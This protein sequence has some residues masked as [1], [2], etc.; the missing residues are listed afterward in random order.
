MV[1][2]RERALARA[3]VCNALLAPSA[4]K[5]GALLQESERV[6]LERAVDRL[7]LSARA[8]QRI[9]RVART[10]ADLGGH[11]QIAGEHL[12]EAIGYRRLDRQLAVAAA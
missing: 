1:A 2:A 8:H 9:V 10:I 6:L 12:M 5:H 11:E 4:L 7:G 3:G